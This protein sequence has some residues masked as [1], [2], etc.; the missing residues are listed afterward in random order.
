MFI[1][2]CSCISTVCKLISSD[3]S[4]CSDDAQGLPQ[5]GSHYLSIESIVPTTFPNIQPLPTIFLPSPLVFQPFHLHHIRGGTF[6]LYSTLSTISPPTTHSH[7]IRVTTR[8]VPPL[9]LLPTSDSPAGHPFEAAL[10][11]G[12]LL[13]IFE[14]TSRFIIGLLQSISFW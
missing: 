8:C 6:P 1:Y 13:I 11:L 4:S 5:E 7:H 10:Y 14:Q 2:T 9:L 3:R 12:N